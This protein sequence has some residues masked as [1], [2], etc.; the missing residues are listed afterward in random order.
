M[1]LNIGIGSVP[2][3]EPVVCNSPADI[4]KSCVGAAE[5]KAAIT[6]TPLRVLAIL[7]GA[8]IAMGG[9]LNTVITNDLGNYIGDGLTR[10]IGGMVFS[11]GL[12][13]VILGGAELFTGNNLVMTTGLLDGKVTLK[14]VLYNWVNVYIFNFVGAVL[15]ALLVYYSG[16]WKFNNGNVG[17][18]ALNAAVGK[19]NLS[20]TEALVRGI[21]CN[22]LVCLAVWLSMAGKDA[23][24][25]I[26]GIMVPVTAFV[27]MGFEHSVANMYFIPM[28]ILLSG[29]EALVANLNPAVLEGLN[30]SGFLLKNLLPVTIGN[31]I[32]GIFFVATAYW[33]V[34]LKPRTPEKKGWRILHGLFQNRL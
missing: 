5:K 14:Q 22:W 17:L 2:T 8:Y 20:F 9:V 1:E 26:L 33:N 24:G 29:Q 10:L 25:K 28:G 19:V 4:A 11:L 7:A 3:V 31:M 32:G 21:L 15:V 13:L 18:K 12:I 16:I 34:Y 6:S 27:A 23:F 30:W